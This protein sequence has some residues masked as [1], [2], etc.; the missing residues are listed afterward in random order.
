MKEE[1]LDRGS[2]DNITVIVLDIRQY[3]AAFGRDGLHVTRVLDRAATGATR[4]G[5]TAAGRR[6][7]S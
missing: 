4:R 5:A 7:A 6:S 3:T 1:A 2:T